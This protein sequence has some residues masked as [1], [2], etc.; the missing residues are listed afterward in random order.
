MA[1]RKIYW[2]VQALPHLKE[3]ISL[4][5]LLNRKMTVMSHL[6][7]MLAHLS[8][9]QSK[10]IDMVLIP[11]LCIIKQVWNV[12]GIS[13]TTD[14]YAIAAPISTWQWQ[15]TYFMVNNTVHGCRWQYLAS[16]HPYCFMPYTCTW[17]LYSIQAPDS[18]PV[19][20][21]PLQMWRDVST[22]YQL[23]AW[24]VGC[25][26]EET[27]KYQALSVIL[28]HLW[29]HQCYSGWDCTMAVLC[30]FIKSWWGPWCWW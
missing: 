15:L 30:N 19:G 4:P 10:N 18:I 12:G 2:R 13:P 22:Q 27:W 23:F 5:H 1:C 17:W 29:H 25:Q 7:L 16:Q 6:Y 14:R 9:L 20:W 21:F 11:S 28:R 24:F 3:M 8:T 26:H